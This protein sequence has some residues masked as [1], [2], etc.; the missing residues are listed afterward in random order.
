MKTFIIEW[1]PQESSFGLEDFSHAISSMEFGDLPWMFRRRCGIRSGDNFYLVKVGDGLE[2]IVMK[3]FFRTQ[4][5]AYS[6]D[7][8]GGFRTLL[9]P[10][11]MVDVRRNENLIRK[12]MLDDS[13]P[14]LP[15]SEECFKLDPSQTTVLS[16]IWEEYF[17]RLPKEAFIG[18]AMG[19]RERPE[20]ILDDAV[21]IAAET[22]YEKRDRDGE[23]AI[24]H[25]IELSFLWKKEN[26]RIASLLFYA[27][28]FSD[29]DAGYVREKGFSEGVADIVC[30]LLCKPGA[31]MKEYVNSI[32][33]SDCLMASR[34][35]IRDMEQHPRNWDAS[36]LE[37]IPLLRRL[38]KSA[39]W[40]LEC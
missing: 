37:N 4:P 26:N 28:R 15:W 21:L 20:A 3:G 12:E 38:H 8:D 36:C 32:I 34:I 14:D 30:A 16:G 25:A 5:E 27:S 6:G 11:F 29:L 17:S 1:N 19:R 7:A 23:P 9:R 22:L 40:E 13:L 31:S 39:G 33:L 18:G 10:T 24:L 35:I 2:G